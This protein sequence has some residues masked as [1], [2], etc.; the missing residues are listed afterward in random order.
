MH[1]ATHLSSLA[2]PVLALLRSV[3]SPL[4]PEIAREVVQRAIPRGDNVS[5][6]VPKRLTDEFT[7]ETAEHIIA[8]IGDTV[9]MREATVEA[10]AKFFLDDRQPGTRENRA[11]LVELLTQLEGFAAASVSANGNLT[12]GSA[13]AQWEDIFITSEE[14]AKLLHVS[15]PHVNKLLDNGTIPGVHK[16]EKGH[17]RVSQ[18]AVL[19]Y[20]KVLKERQRRGLEQMAEESAELGLYEAESQ[21]VRVHHAAEESGAPPNLSR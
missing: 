20:K 1:N 11:K 13:A 17:R 7:S 18:E 16:T 14:A 6:G 8:A 10:F 4:A 5:E 15:R 2:P 12:T 9:Q 21:A 3:L 19:E